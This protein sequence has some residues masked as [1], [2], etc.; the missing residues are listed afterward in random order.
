[1][2]ST[3]KTITEAVQTFQRQL[4]DGDE[5]SETV[6]DVI[7]RSKREDAWQRLLAY[8]LTPSRDHGYG[9]EILVSFLHT[10]ER[11]TAIRGLDGPYD[12]VRV[13]I[14]KTTSKG[15]RID[16]LLSQ[17]EQW[18]L[19]IELKVEAAEHG[20]QTKSYVDAQYLGGRDTSQFPPA[21]RHFLYVSQAGVGDPVADE[22]ETITWE[23]FLQRWENVVDYHR[24]AEGAYPT[25]GIAQFGEFLAQIRKEAGEGTGNMEH[26]YRDMS[27]AKNAYESLARTLAEHLE[28][29]VREITDEGNTQLRVRRKP[30][31]GFPRFEH[32][33]PNR[34]EIDKPL[35]QAGRDK[36][37]VL[38][39]FN[40][41]LKPHIGPGDSQRS[42]SVAVNL[43]I[44]GGR[45]LKRGL[46]EGFRARVQDERYRN[47]GF[48]RP[49]ANSKWH[50][51]SKEVVLDETDQPLSDLLDSFRTLYQF[52]SDL[53]QL[54][55]E[56]IEE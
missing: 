25:R 10:V 4:R 32:G 43:D 20:E 8:F 55:T 18:F 45:S 14:E 6:L 3:E 44:R 41:H 40:F 34:I 13:E 47:N 30:A 33:A 38:F 23:Q 26:F 56:A 16:V 51:L 35:W 17:P 9:D 36:P 42:P 54:A 48:S 46:R 28:H 12:S 53:D 5:P 1:M 24:T 37:T 19:C 11:N 2:G 22:F 49:H 52:E 21:G 27:R 29:G 39:E 7:E 50:F 15:D 31:R